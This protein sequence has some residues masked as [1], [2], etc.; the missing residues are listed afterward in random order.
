MSTIAAICT[1]LSLS[2]IGMVRLSGEGALRIAAK[3]VRPKDKNR[4]IPALHGY[5]GLLGRVF[6]KQG[7]FDDAVVFVYRAPK[8]YTGE[9]VAE[10]CCHGGPYLLKRTLAACLA[11]GAVLAMP[12]EFTK[13]AFLAGK[14]SL[15]QAEAVASLIA[16]RSDEAA[17]AAL[18]ARDGALFLEISV[19]KEA[20]VSLSASLAAWID[21]PD[22][23][24]D[25]VFAAS[26]SK[27]LLQA[28]ERLQ[29][30]LTN[31]GKGALFR[32]GVDTAIIG[33]PNVGK[34]TLMNLL[35]GSQRSIV[36]EQAGTT[37]DV[38]ES[39]ISLGGVTLV[40]SDTAGIRDTQE[41][42]EAAGVKRAYERAARAQ[43]ILLLLDGAKALTREDT[44]LLERLQN[45][46]I[47]AVLNKIDKGRALDAQQVA[48]LV[49]AVV[50]LSAKTGQGRE[51]LEQA[52]LSVLEL[53]G[54]EPGQPFLANER[55]R[56]AAAAALEVL[57]EA[58]KAQQSG[59]TLDAINI[60][61]DSAIDELLTLS[62]ERASQ[63]V[64]DEVFSKFCVGK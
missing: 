34:S 5:T 59:V 62:G 57:Q 2:G 53:A 40:L 9:D 13:R 16:A 41:P 32:D 25:E 39:E 3:V 33:L 10:I 30:L 28:E 14:V 60:L 31:Y 55:Q 22:E 24:Q 35:S 47:I 19:I 64:V 51:L 7:E 52:V 43:L 63:A 36:T 15:T 48:P 8:S 18:A 17:T 54:L 61:L 58:I 1:P 50:P 11:A 37:R 12:G 21:Y 20:L 38:I 56:Q 6:D 42:I 44:A 27:G 46:P 23:E 4:R 49:R 26:L 29:A 45:K